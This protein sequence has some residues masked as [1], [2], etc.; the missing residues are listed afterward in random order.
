M[1][2]THTC[3]E[4]RDSHK[5]E[6]VILC[7][8]V[9]RRRDHG[10]LIF[11]DLRD[12]YGFTQVVFDP[13]NAESFALAEKMRPEWVLKVKGTVRSRLE[14]AEREDN[15]TGAIEVLVSEVEILSESKTPPFEIDQ[16]KEINEELRLQYRYLD[17]RKPRMQEMLR[18]RDAFIQHIRKYMHGKDFI[19]VQTP[20]LANSSPEGAR[21]YLVPSRLHK[22][23]F[24]ALPQAPQ[25]F[26]QLLMVAGLDRYFQIAPCFRDEDPRADRHPGEFY[27]LD[28][29][30]SFVE[31]EDIFNVVEPLMVEL[32]EQF[33]D[34]EVI[35]SPFPRLPWKESMT[36]YG[37]DKPDLRFD[38]EIMPC[39]DLLRDCEFKVFAEAIA[40]KGVVHALRI[41]N[42]SELSRK[43]ID[44]LTAAAATYGAKGLAYIVVK[45]N[46]LQSPIVKFL[47][48]DLSQ[49][50]VD[51]TG[52]KVGDI[53]FFCADQWLTVCN[54]LGAV[55]D[56]IGKMRGLK[57]S[58][59]AAW[60]W[61]VDF[62]M[63]EYNEREGKIDFSHNPFSMP[64][65]G[66]AD[67]EN[68]DPLDILG[69]QYDL[70]CNG[71]EIS[72][73]AIRNY[74]PDIMYKA[75]E[76][77]GYTKAEVDAKF[78]GMINAFKYGA[79]PHGGFAPGVDR[80]MMVLWECPSI[81]D[82]YAF[83][84]NG[85]AQD[86]MMGAPSNV[87]DQ[88]LEELHIRVIGEE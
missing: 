70:F 17:L 77:A 86:M 69:Y 52:A 29:E 1:I 27:Q 47:G 55:R 34:K 50:L 65:G 66:M 83:P 22:G 85:K 6:E 36:R 7:G 23:Q 63:Y 59:K 67:L 39:T 11:I 12:R 18:R 25:Q 87:S 14:G 37:S 8:W 40:N 3:G 82:I 60:G 16:E 54:S 68:K 61:I 56:N 49:K 4:L 48:E 19:E 26:K 72:S 53:V 45:D 78:G 64:Q 46:E 24:Y 10:G 33:G 74:R 84:K 15:P 35:N 9:H 2:R 73:G 88:Q 75:F 79:P 80:L 51:E 13:K 57:D 42:G 76:I 62:P 81:R 58:S 71:F 32:S 5:K 21:D 20:I 41:P 31:Q 38:F 44:D 43:D 30:M 28:L